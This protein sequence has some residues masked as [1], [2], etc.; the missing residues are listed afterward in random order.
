MMIW[1]TACEWWS[2]IAGS[3]PETT[4]RTKLR[5]RG[6]EQE[7]VL[8]V[9]CEILELRSLPSALTI[10]IDYSY[11]TN[12]F[13]DTQEKRDLFQSV[14][15]EYAVRIVDDLAAIKPSGSNTWSAQFTSPSTGQSTSV[16]NPIV[17]A[18]TIIVFAGGRDLGGDTL[19]IGGPGGY[20]ATGSKS[21]LATVDRRGQAGAAGLNPTDFGPWGGSITFDSSGTNW[22]FGSTTEGLDPGEADFVS[23]AMHE[24]GHIFGFGTSQSFDNLITSGGFAGSRSDAEFDGLGRPQL[25]DDDSHWAEGTIDGG[26]EVAMDPSILLGTRKLFTNL[27]WAALDDI[28]WTLTNTTQISP[29]VIT[30]PGAIPTFVRGGLRTTLDLGATFSNPSSLMLKGSQ[31]QVSIT[32]NPGKYDAISISTGNGITKSGA[33]LKYNGVSIGTY[34]NGSGSKAFK[35]TFS[36]KATDEAVQACLRNIQ[37]YT[38]SNQAGLLDRTLSL[39]MLNV[40]GQSSAPTTKVVHV[41]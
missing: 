4:D 40:N 9:E 37:F 7:T 28:G 26:R 25:A 17:P 10:M 2:Q 15:N 5:R 19:G 8:V 11:D 30:L 31:L 33:T 20:N 38:T 29:P 36:S 27:D 24:L 32:G 6:A 16:S 3:R 34:S 35:I 12:N 14:A 21:W 39:R 13:F 41:V 1:E 23:V 22:F 18:D